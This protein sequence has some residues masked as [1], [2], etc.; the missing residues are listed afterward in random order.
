MTHAHPFHTDE[1]VRL[2]RIPRPSPDAARRRLEDDSGL[3]H[4]PLKTLA[5]RQTLGTGD[6]V[7]RALW[8]AERTRL[9]TLT[10]RLSVGWPRRLPSR[11]DPLGLRFVAAALLVVAL[12]GVGGE[13]GPRLLRALTPDLP[14]WGAPS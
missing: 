6:A 13:T 8:A 5:D 7:A 9:E 12:G 1:L 4:R 10:R 14:A 2:R 3:A 11:G